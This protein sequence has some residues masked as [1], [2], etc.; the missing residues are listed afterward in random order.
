[1]TLRSLD[2]IPAGQ[3]LSTSVAIVGAGPAGITIAL[4]LSARGVD[5]ILLEAGGLD[6]DE[7]TQQRYEGEL[8]TD[9]TLTYPPLEAWRLRMLGGTSNHWGGWCRRLEA[10]VFGSRPW[11]NDDTDWPFDRSELEHGYR[12]AHET[13]ELGRDLYDADRIQADLGLAVWD[14]LE[15]HG[16]EASMWRYSPPT[17]FGER[18]RP[19][20]EAAALDLIIGANVVSIESDRGAVQSL[21]VVGE[22][23]EV[24]YV[25]ADVFVMASGGLESVRQLL[26]LDRSSATAIDGSGWLGHGFMEHPHG[27]V[28]AMVVDGAIAGD[29]GG[30]LAIFRER[31][32]DI[33]GVDVRGGLTVTPDACADLGL[34]NM[35]F[36]IDPVGP[37]DLLLDGLPRGA[38]VSELVELLSDGRAG[39]SHRLFA[40]SE[41]RPDRASRISLTGAT[42]DLGLQ[43]IRLDWHVEP[44]DLADLTT[45]VTMIANAVAGLGIAVVHNPGI[46]SPVAGLSGGGHHMG[47]ARMHEDAGRGVVDPDLRVHSLR[48][49]YVC[50]ASTFPSSGYSNP[51]LTIV[52]LAHRLAG[53]LSDR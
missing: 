24:R 42:D 50:S 53:E 16:L 46:V 45:G 11:L 17:L 31:R 49:L 51:T 41:Q 36:T 38:A 14:D 23:A 12:R 18:Y 2:R 4:D 33:D 26:L 39:A 15:R 22:D 27:H 19:D 5:V 44:D 37:G 20:L 13:C 35:S 1:M 48:N 29:S 21:T 6:F 7:R 30:P 28:G 9:D 47:G 8:G 52:A 40:R 3:R 32:Q 43:R 34:V 10:N 25:S